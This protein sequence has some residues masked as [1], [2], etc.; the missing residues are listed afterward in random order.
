IPEKAPLIA[1]HI[2][3]NTIMC[4]SPEQQ[5]LLEHPVSSKIFLHGP[6][7]TGKT[8][9]GVKWLKKLL[10]SG[11]PAHNIMVFVPQRSLAKPYQD[12]MRN[13]LFQAH[14]LINTTTLGGLA[15]RMIDLFWPMISRDTGVASPN[16]PPHFL[17]LETAQYY[18]AH[19]VR[20]LMD[21][22][23]FLG[24]LTIN[25]NRIY[26]QILDNLNKAA[27]VGFSHQDIGDRLKAAWIGDIAQFNIY[28]DVQA[29]ANR[30]RIF[31]LEHNL[32]DF[33]LQVEIFLR[34][35]WPSPL[36]RNHLTQS[37]RH[38]I[39]DNIEEDTP[40][41]HDILSEWLPDFDSALV[42]FDEEAG[43][44]Y[45]LGADVQSA[46]SLK[47]KCHTVIKFTQNQVN[48]PGI[49]QIKSG[50]RHAIAQLEGNPQEEKPELNL[51][52]SGL[53]IPQEINKYFPDMVKWVAE[54]IKILVDED[55]PPGEI[56]ILAPFMPDV[57][58]FAISNQLGEFGIPHVSHRPS[59]ALRDEPATQAML[60]L[61]SAAF[62]AWKML[63]KRINMAFALMQVIDGLDLVRAQLLTAYVYKENAEDFPLQPF[64]SAPIDVRD[65]VTYRVGARYD[66][67]QI[68]LKA[69]QIS[70]SNT[71]DF[72]LSRLFGE[73]LSQ[74]GFGFHNDLNS[75]NTISNL[76]ESIQKFRWVV[77][78][79]VPKEMYSI[80]KEYIQMVQDGVI[81]AQYVRT[82]DGDSTNAVFL[83][84]AYTFLISNHPVDIQF[85]LDVGSPSWYQ[86]L[87]QPLT[88]PYV[89]SRHW[90]QGNT[91]DA[92]KEVFAA[93]ESLH[94]LAIGLLNRCRKKVYLGMSELD[95]RG[96]DNRGL[97]VRIFQ[98]ILQR[99]QQ[100]QN[101]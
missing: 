4:L 71:L 58:R 67:L 98:H 19:I 36:C 94:R 76:I 38:L 79:Q 30:F 47:R 27:L 91:W 53:V 21:D 14:S 48:A 87:E 20:P 70:D 56:V 51:L 62:P 83:S 44:R 96:Y 99:A 73:V 89:L 92:E 68:W 43:Y 60:T 85:W 90:Q 75:G 61:V 88:H 7:G 66:Q 12:S 13:D 23:G 46:F 17:T 84:P 15:R 22:E 8:T 100:V 6:A 74:S 10:N 39:V 57:L 29:C 3:Y 35:L 5:S 59:R 69:A 28:D 54:Q 42:I 32:L 95:V 9:A 49:I 52:Q 86:R 1:Q 72:F 26:S 63:P 65:R 93:Q 97:L 77:G 55:V 81:A 37:Y 40:V 31:C 24:N 11:I 80:G 33:S 82:G 2:E 41:S 34:L 18:M 64:D 78:D 16:Q 45:F 101:D 25:R 50:I